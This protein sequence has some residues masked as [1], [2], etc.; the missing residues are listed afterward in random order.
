MSGM[1]TIDEAVRATRMDCTVVGD[2]TR[3]FARPTTL[4]EASEGAIVWVAKGRDD[5][6]QLVSAARASVVVCDPEA[7]GHAPALG[8]KT[9][10]VVA[11]PR[12][13]FLRIVAA[14]FQGRPGPGIH[15]T[16]SIHPEARLGADVYVG[17][18]TYVGR[19]T[20]GAGSVIH[21]HVHI[22]DDVE[23]GQRVV[24]HAGTV[25]GADG[26]GYER[27]EDGVL[28]KF[29]HVGR[30]VIEDDV[31]IGANTT[32]DRGSLG[33]TIIR[34]RARIDNLVHVAHNVEIGEDCAV[35]AKVMIGGSTRIGARAWLAPSV[36]LRDG[37]RIGA[38]SLIGLGSVVT[39]SVPAGETWVGSPARKWPREPEEAK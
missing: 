37:L 20:V 29:P 7:A 18:F 9:L 34:K 5:K 25:I 33:K 15:T 1:H 28:E 12:L 32:I 3:S 10:L 2:A 30:V 14:L 35:I 38:D 16:A 27:N 17:P 11:E 21:G 39:K 23:I 24:V 36:T 22:Y 13:A 31:E 8:D 6:K 4:D 19:S 26:F